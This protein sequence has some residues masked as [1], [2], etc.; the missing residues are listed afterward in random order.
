MGRVAEVLSIERRS[1]GGH[2][3]ELKVD[4]D[5]EP[6]TVEYFQAAGLDAPP[7]PGDFVALEES[8]GTGAEQA[9]GVIDTRNEGDA[10]AGEVRI[11]ARD[12]G[13]TPVT[14]IYCKRD[15]SIEIRSLTGQAV[16]INGV[17]ID[18]DGNVEAPGNIESGGNIEAAGDIEA[19]GNVKGAEV[20][21]A[22]IVLGTHVHNV[23]PPVGAPTGS[24]VSPPP[25][26]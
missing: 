16:T 23:P 17:T 6:I 11:Y 18:A 24:G 10:L 12:A 14:E 5:G 2:R 19:T 25:T 22:S 3:V 20:S 4:P 15:G 8:A 1:D 13:G 21:N 26:P 9:T 7:L